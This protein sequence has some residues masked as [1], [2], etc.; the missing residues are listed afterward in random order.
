MNNEKYD[1]F[2]LLLKLKSYLVS[3]VDDDTDDSSGLYYTEE[4]LRAKYPDKKDEVLSMLHRYKLESDYEIVFNEQVHHIFKSMVDGE[5][6]VRNLDN[7]LKQQKINS[8]SPSEVEKFLENFQL[9]RNNTIKE[10][11]GLLL[12]VTKLWSDYHEIESQVDD[13][14]ELDEKEVLRPDEEEKFQALDKTASKS[15]D[16]ISL[17]TKEYLE[18]WID[19]LFKFGGDVQ[20]REFTAQFEKLKESVD[21][22]YNELFLKSGLHPKGDNEDSN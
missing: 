7:I 18:L 16:E 6:N 21:Y 20:L 12:N 3:M 9:N 5:S 14:I 17:L 15:L 13:Y 4:Y 11:V 19:F 22:Y 1:L 8:F 10:M 2:M